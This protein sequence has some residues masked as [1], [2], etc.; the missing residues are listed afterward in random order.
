MDPTVR[1]RLG[2]TYA[3]IVGGNAGFAYLAT[4]LAGQGW[5]DSAVAGLLFAHSAAATVGGPWWSARADASG[6]RAAT[7]RTVVTLS[8]I[9][10]L[11]LLLATSLPTWAA[12]LLGFG[13]V[14][15]AAGPLL[16][17]TTLEH[18]GSARDRYAALRL[19]GSIAYLLLVSFGGL[20]QDLHPRGGVAL[21][22][23]TL[24]L[25]TLT[26]RSLPEPPATPSAPAGR[27]RD[28]LADPTLLGLSVVALL[29]GVTLTTYDHLFTLL[30][31]ARGLSPTIAG[32]ALGVG[33]AVEVGVMATAHRWLRHFG[34]GT[35][36]WWSVASGVPRWLLTG[37]DLPPAV[38]IAT[39]ALHGVGFGL[40]WVTSVHLYARHAPAGRAAGAQALLLVSTYGLGRMVAMGSAAIAL[41]TL[42]IEGWFLTLTV[43]SVA[44]TLV[45]TTVRFRDP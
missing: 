11:G 29:H 19:W 31:D 32:A 27:W 4:T 5:S 43:I 42:P 45:A 33:V 30:T 44:A 21:I 34:A 13:F 22:V 28:L 38:L 15:G 8:A 23:G 2:L 6:Q 17:A 9:A 36:W 25:A 7:L 24:L 20:V 35:L 26:L 37:L 39:Q 40:F 3:A 12:V 18:L 41:R 10:S 16:D 1:T 14:R